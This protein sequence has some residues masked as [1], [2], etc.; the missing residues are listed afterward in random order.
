M[1]NIEKHC[2]K[3]SRDA[4]AYCHLFEFK[5]LNNVTVINQYIL[6]N[7]FSVL[8]GQPLDKRPCDAA[9]GTNSKHLTA[10]FKVASL[11]TISGPEDV[12]PRR[13]W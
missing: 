6:N 1:P 3:R 9:N 10:T 5:Y 13:A 11:S 7:Y 4:G 8:S 12:D 2:S